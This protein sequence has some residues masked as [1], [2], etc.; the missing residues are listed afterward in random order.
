MYLPEYTRRMKSIAAQ[1]PD[2]KGIRDWTWQ[3]GQWTVKRSARM[4][5][6][7][8]VCDWR[9]KQ[10]RLADHL[11]RP[12]NADALEDT[13]LHEVAHLLA[14][15]REGHGPLWKYWAKRLGA[16]PER[17]GTVESGPQA[18][19]HVFCR[20]CDRVVARRFRRPT[21]LL[22]GRYQSRCC[23]SGLDAYRVV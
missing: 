12:E 20:N 5:R 19:W 16:K 14:G 23:K 13:F 17:C 18:N 1:Y 15:S 8:G 6:K 7:M 10:I 22:N 3:L 11:F 21:K 9:L 4:K 2:A